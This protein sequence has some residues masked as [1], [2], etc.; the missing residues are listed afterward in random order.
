MRLPAHIKDPTEHVQSVNAVVGFDDD[1]EEH[2]CW[3]HQVQM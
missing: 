2:T 3:L 1:D